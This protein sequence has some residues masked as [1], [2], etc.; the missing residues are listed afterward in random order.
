MVHGIWHIKLYQFC[1]F[2]ICLQSN[3]IKS[4][5]QDSIPVFRRV[6]KCLAE[7][8]NVQLQIYWLLSTTITKINLLDF[9]KFRMTLFII[10][11]TYF[12]VEVCTD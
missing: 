7:F 10:K 3:L 8:R 2:K 11:T 1:L 9:L 5:E 12:S 6:I 4:S